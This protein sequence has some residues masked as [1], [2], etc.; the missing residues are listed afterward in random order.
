MIYSTHNGFSNTEI[1]CCITANLVNCPIY[2]WI[3][4]Q[5]EKDH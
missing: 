1:V 2:I 3:Y 5:K 4:G